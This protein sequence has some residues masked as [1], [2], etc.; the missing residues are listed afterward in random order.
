[1]LH[2]AAL[3]H[4]HQAQRPHHLG[5]ALHVGHGGGIGGGLPQHPSAADGFG[6][7]LV[8]AQDAEALLPQHPDHGGQ[9][10]IIPG[11][12]R[13]SDP[14]HDARAIRVGA[15]IQQRRAA[16]RADQHQVGAR[17]GTQRGQDVGRS[18]HP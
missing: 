1:M 15:Q 14:G 13:A 18:A 11:E 12:G 2:D 10:A 6:Q 16:D 17:M 3:A 9:H 5:A 4:V 7:H 8:R